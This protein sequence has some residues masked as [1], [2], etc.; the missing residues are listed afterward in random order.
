MKFCFH[1]FSAQKSSKLENSCP[2]PTLLLGY[3]VGSPFRLDRDWEA[4]LGMGWIEGQNRDSLECNCIDWILLGYK[5]MAL[6]NIG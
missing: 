6:V 2:Y 1:N 4:E 3:Y 5:Y